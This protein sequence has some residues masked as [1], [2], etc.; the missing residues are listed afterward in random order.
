MRFPAASRVYIKCILIDGGGGGLVDVLWFGWGWLVGWKLGDGRLV[1]EIFRYGF[2]PGNVPWQRSGIAR[3]MGG[4]SLVLG[5]PFNCGF[6]YSFFCFCFCTL[7]YS[8][9]NKKGDYH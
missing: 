2:V 8:R 1:R 9:G 7:C 4:H 6:R 5:T 3:C